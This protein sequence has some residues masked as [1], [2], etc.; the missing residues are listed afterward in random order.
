MVL[1]GLL[2][3]A[4]GNVVRLFGGDDVERLAIVG[5][6]FVEVEF[7][8]GEIIG[9]TDE[10]HVE[11]G[12]AQHGGDCGVVVLLGEFPGLVGH[13][14]DIGRDAQPAGD[15][16][17]HG[18]LRGV[19][20]DGP[21]GLGEKVVEVFWRCGH[22][23]VLC[24]WVW[25]AGPGW[26]LRTALMMAFEWGLWQVRAVM[27]RCCPGVRGRVGCAGVLVCG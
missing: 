27:R 12:F 3:F 17:L 10:V 1:D 6:A 2:E 24:W 15:A 21:G 4:E 22:L 26:V 11:V 25:R 16:L 9:E 23:T 8:F 5:V 14:L 13:F 19:G 7:V 20:H 18:G